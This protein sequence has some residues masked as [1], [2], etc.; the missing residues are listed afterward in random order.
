MENM[1]EDLGQKRAI[2]ANPILKIL[3]ISLKS[4]ANFE[5]IE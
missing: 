4:V 5:N 3:K 2:L 1:S